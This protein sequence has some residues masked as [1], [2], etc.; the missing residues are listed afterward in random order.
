[1]NGYLLWKP[2]SRI[3]WSQLYRLWDRCRKSMNLS[4]LYIGKDY[5]FKQNLQGYR[6]TR[7]HFEFRYLKSTTFWNI[8]KHICIHR[9]CLAFHQ[10]LITVMILSNRNETILFSPGQV[11]LNEFRDYKTEDV[12]LSRRKGRTWRNTWGETKIS[13]RINEPP[14]LWLTSTIGLSFT[15]EHHGAFLL[16]WSK[17]RGL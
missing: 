12:L 15:T 3:Q 1:M 14:R 5:Y 10:I 4:V 7:A 17:A 11:S 2:R 13:Q 6:K 16:S 8:T 9:S